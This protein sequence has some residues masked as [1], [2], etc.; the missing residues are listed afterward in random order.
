MV[1]LAHESLAHAWPRLRSWLD[2]DVE[3]HRVMRH[4]ALTAD[5]WDTMGRPDSELYRGAVSPKRW[6]GE[7]ESTLT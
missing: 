6:S 1:E 5:E 4:L 3:G 2:E 7:R